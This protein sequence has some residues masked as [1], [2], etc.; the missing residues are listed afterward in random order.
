MRNSKP[1]KLRRGLRKHVKVNSDAIT[2][3][4][5]STDN[6][7]LASGSWDNT[8]DASTL[9]TVSAPFEGHSKAIYGLA[10]SLNSAILVSDSEDGTIKL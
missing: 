5:I 7:L 3:I 8:F 9:E 6:K 4:D 2:C 1:V 10:L